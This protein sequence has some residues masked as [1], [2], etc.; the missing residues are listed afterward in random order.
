MTQSSVSRGRGRVSASS[1]DHAARRVRRGDPR[2][3]EHRCRVPGLGDARRHAG[4]REIRAASRR[5]PLER[6]KVD[7]GVPLISPALVDIRRSSKPGTYSRHARRIIVVDLVEVTVA[8]TDGSNP[9]HLVP[10]SARR[11][12]RRLPDPWRARA[13]DLGA[14]PA[15][16]G[17]TASSRT[18]SH[19]SS[20]RIAT[21]SAAST[22]ATTAASSRPTIAA[23]SPRSPVLARAARAGPP[24]PPRALAPSSRC[25]PNTSGIRD[26]APM[27]NDRRTAIDAELKASPRR[28]PS[29]RAPSASPERS[30]AQGGGRR[31]R[32]RAGDHDAPLGTAR[33]TARR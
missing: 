24:P 32:R 12:A 11:E 6:A 21:P 5:G 25:S 22:P 27:A 9:A 7:G 13:P 1:A 14:P 18:A 23:A 26:G 30:T 20:T 16:P 4:R 3:V 28:A 17:R 2:A 31:P 8:R 19:A 33:R 29:W 15:R 10:N